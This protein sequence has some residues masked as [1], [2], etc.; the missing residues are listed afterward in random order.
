MVRFRT[1]DCKQEQPTQSINVHEEALWTVEPVSPVA[2]QNLAS[3]LA[4]SGSESLSAAMILTTTVSSKAPFSGD[5]RCICEMS[6]STALLA[7][8]VLEAFI[9]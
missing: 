7:E 9:T 3:C 6:A 8:V 4:R 1:F 5:G 2:S